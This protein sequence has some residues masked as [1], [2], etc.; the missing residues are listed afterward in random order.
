M[1][2]SPPVSG[3]GATDAKV[4]TWTAMVVTWRMRTVPR[5]NAATT[6][7]RKA[8]LAI[9]VFR[10]ARCLL[11]EIHAATKMKTASLAK[12]IVANAP[13]VATGIAKMNI[14]L[15]VQQIV[16]NVAAAERARKEKK[17]RWTA[18]SNAFSNLL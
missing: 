13:I 6:Y 11:V 4:L 1:A 15:L 12:E 18:L 10:I 16:A 2:V 7:V 3:A 17:I 9:A 14:A 8:N 5:Q